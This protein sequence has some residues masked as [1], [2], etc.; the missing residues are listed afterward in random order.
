MKDSPKQR[1]EVGNHH[2]EQ[3]N[4]CKPPPSCPTHLKTAALEQQPVQAYG[5]ERKIFLRVGAHQQSARVLIPL[6]R[7]F[8]HRPR[9]SA[10]SGG[11]DRHAGRVSVLR[12]RP[13]SVV[14]SIRQLFVDL[15]STSIAA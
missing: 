4:L 13:R 7:T 12:R 14:A 1:N 15:R 10:I 3:A 6:C 8:A 5:A 11:G 2:P 9:S